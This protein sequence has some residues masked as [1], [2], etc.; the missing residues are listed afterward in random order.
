M[1]FVDVTYEYIKNSI[2]AGDY[3]GK[4][5]VSIFSLVNCQSYFK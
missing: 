1:L 3:S 4:L 2:F 5:T